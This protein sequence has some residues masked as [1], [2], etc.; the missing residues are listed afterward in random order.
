M[1]VENIWPNKM[2]YSIVIPQKAIVFGTAIAVEMKF[3]SLLKGLK[4]GIIRCLLIEIQEFTLP[5]GAPN[6][7]RSHKNTRDIETWQFEINEE[8]HRNDILGEEG[9]EGFVLNEILP[10]PKSL[11]K[12]LQDCDTHGIKIRHKVK[13]NIALHNPDGHTSELRATLPVT[14]FLSPNVPLDAAGN[15]LDQTP[16]NVNTMDIG[17]HAP[18]L[19]G[20]HVLDQLYAELDYNGVITPGA[21]SGMNT[22]FYAHSRNASVES[23]AAPGGGVRPDALQSRLQNLTGGSRQSYNGGRRSGGTT[24]RF[25]LGSGTSSAPREA[26]GYFDHLSN[27]VP[28]S[29]PLSRHP[30]NEDEQQPRSGVLSGVTSGYQTPEHTEFSEAL[31]KV[32]SYKTAIREPVR[33]YTYED[34]AALPCYE[35]AISMP[36]S[37]T[38]AQSYGA[39]PPAQRPSPPPAG[40]VRANTAHERST[41]NTHVSVPSSSSSTPGGL[42]H[43]R[44][45][46]SFQSLSSLGFS[47]FGSRRHGGE[48]EAERRLHILRAR[49]KAH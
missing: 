4:I 24:P 41:S 6:Q 14:I 48:D 32:P 8:E 31:N 40:P 13:F 3:T 21:S 23:L 22:P 45:N 43:S 7:E 37:P 29:N 15:L 49:G 39:T 47:A 34:L 18:P 20:E 27:S 28:R 17:S 25:E 16:N 5:G 9:Q 19:Y 44:R 38:R 26:P 33:N 2:E 10:L 11:K 1:T 42:N 12:C 35:A 30:S 46:H 36:P